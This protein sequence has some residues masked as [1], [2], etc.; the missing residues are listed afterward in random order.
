MSGGVFTR[1]ER[2]GVDNVFR[3]INRILRGR[4]PRNGSM[5]EECLHNSWS[6]DILP[7]P[8]QL[9]LGLWAASWQH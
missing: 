2:C 8:D 5:A 4:V 1:H 6:A 7:R 3:S 9:D